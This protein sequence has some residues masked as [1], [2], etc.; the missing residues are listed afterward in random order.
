MLIPFPLFDPIARYYID[1][2]LFS[3]QLGKSVYLPVRTTVLF[4]LCVTAWSATIVFRWVGLTFDRI[5]IG[6]SKV[7][8]QGQI[9]F[10]GSH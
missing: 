7:K 6:L 9:S 10:T 3:S 5:A 2:H 8:E 4:E 1:N